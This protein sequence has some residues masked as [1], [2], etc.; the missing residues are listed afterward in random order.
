MS[1]TITSNLPKPL[2]RVEHIIKDVRLVAWDGCHKIYLAMDAEGEA[3]F[4][5]HYSFII[6]GA[7]EDMLVE[8]QELWDASCSLRFITAVYHNPDNPN[9][10][11][12]SI[13]EQFWEEK[14]S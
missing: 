3:W 4:R 6:S 8:I 13:V 10:G 2:D 11:F 12:V 9:A 14:P 1:K 5:E 7:P